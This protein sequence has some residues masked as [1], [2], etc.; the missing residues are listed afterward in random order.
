MASV[1]AREGHW[2]AVWRL[3]FRN[4]SSDF[5]SGFGESSEA[6]PWLMKNKGGRRGPGWS[7]ASG[8]GARVTAGTS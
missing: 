3:R 7:Q 4:D 5:A 1:P 2:S 6:D 8:R